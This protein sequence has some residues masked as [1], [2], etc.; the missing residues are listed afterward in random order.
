MTK[1]D[2]CDCDPSRDGESDPFCT[3]EFSAFVLLLAYTLTQHPLFAIS[4]FAL[5]S[6]GLAIWF[7]EVTRRKN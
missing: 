6:S 1:C 7:S 4:S 2:K 3:C 5:L